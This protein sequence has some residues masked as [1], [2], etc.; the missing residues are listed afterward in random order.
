[1]MC[2]HS[3]GRL[4]AESTFSSSSTLGGLLR[5]TRPWHRCKQGVMLQEIVFFLFEEY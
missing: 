3:S 2:V 5:E 4:M 1:M